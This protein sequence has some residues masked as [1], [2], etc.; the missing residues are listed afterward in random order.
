MTKLNATGLSLLYSTYLGGSGFEE[1]RGIAVDATGQA[2]V[3]GLTES[4]DFP[5]ANPLQVTNAGFRDAFVTKLNA[6]G[7]SLLWSDYLG[8]A[9]TTG[10]MAL[11]WTRP[12]R[13]T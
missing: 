8:G 1:G 2:Y 10:A 9:V 7:V 13:R 6:A 12:A 3:T 4:T 11:P 5:T